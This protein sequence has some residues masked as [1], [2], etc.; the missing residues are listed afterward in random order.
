MV[1]EARNIWELI[2]RR[3]EESPDREM[4]VDEAGQRLT[5]GDFKDRSERV[6]AGLAADGVGADDVVSWVLP[7]WVESMVLF[8]AL[9]RL[10]PSA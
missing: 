5:F 7:T 2:V 8:A 9:R 6:A 4:A 1:L 3:A 10:G